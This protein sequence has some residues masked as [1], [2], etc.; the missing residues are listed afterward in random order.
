MIDCTFP[1]VCNM[2]VR[3]CESFPSLEINGGHKNFWSWPVGQS[4]EE[5]IVSG[6]EPVVRTELAPLPRLDRQ[7]LTKPDESLRHSLKL[8]Q[9]KFP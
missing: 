1:D 8:A 7:V 6:G 4:D 9:G 3:P 2:S 5:W